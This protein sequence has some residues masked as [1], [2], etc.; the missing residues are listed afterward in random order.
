MSF[1]EQNVRTCAQETAKAI[2]RLG[3]N[4]TF[5]E[6]RILFVKCGSAISEP[7]SPLKSLKP[8]FKQISLALD[9]FMI[10]PT[11]ETRLYL[12]DTLQGQTSIKLLLAPTA[13]TIQAK[14][15]KPVAAVPSAAYNSRARRRRRRR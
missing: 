1:T 8:W 12:Q 10:M 14:S 9:K 4:G 13:A 11:D 3:V 7:A 15:Q 6:V 5:E 2:H